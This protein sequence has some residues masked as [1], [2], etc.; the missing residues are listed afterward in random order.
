MT[1]TSIS[2]KGLLAKRS[3]WLLMAA[4]AWVLLSLLTVPFLVV[5]LWRALTSDPLDDYLATHK[6]TAK[7][8]C[9]QILYQA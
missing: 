1:D 7:L 8:T 9:P 3:Q 4:S 6:S 5:S 2:S